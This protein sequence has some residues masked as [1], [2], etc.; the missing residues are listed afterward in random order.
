MARRATELGLATGLVLVAMFA[1]TA[2]ASACGDAKSASATKASCASESRA[3]ACAATGA[4]TATVPASPSILL[5]LAS[6]PSPLATRAFPALPGFSQPQP[7]VAGLMAF[8]DP[9]TGLLTGP[10]GDLQVPDDLARTLAPQ[11]TLTPVTLPDGSV[12]VDL[13][14]TLMDYYVM[15]IDPLGRRSIQCVQ[16]PRQA[17]APTL[18]II[19]PMA[20][21]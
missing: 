10:T 8:I 3:A 4:K 11:V 19:L 17:L 5:P 12:M 1:F 16:D 14:G 20:D 21:R 2:G 9:E 18:P 7:I 15:T 13:Q 6:A